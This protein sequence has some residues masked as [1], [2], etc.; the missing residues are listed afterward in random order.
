MNLF[1]ML[2]ESQN[3]DTV[4]QLAR[5]FGLGQDDTQNVLKQLM[6]MLSRGMRNNSKQPGGMDAL[7]KALQS[8]NHQRYIENPNL[9]D[10][11]STRNEG[12]A[13]LGHIF[14]N[15]DVSRNVAAHASAE[16]GISSAI[17]RKMLPVVATIAMGA[18]GKKSGFGGTVSRGLLGSLLGGVVGKMFGG[19]RSTSRSS[20]GMLTSLLDMDNDG[21][22]YDDV[23]NM[24]RKLI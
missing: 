24:A 23:L 2:L 5:Q 11:E 4:G 3:S 7:A 8:G 1:D 6:P 13:I 9:L 12:N 10:Q 14:G 21:S 16:T 17:I 20:G 22:V 15:K 19:G 18:L